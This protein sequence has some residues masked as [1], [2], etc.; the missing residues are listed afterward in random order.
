M[1][2]KWKAM[3]QKGGDLMFVSNYDHSIDDKGRFIM[4]SKFR[5]Q[6]DGRCVVTQGLD[7]NCLYI[8]QVSEWD[9]F[10]ERLR[11]LPN[12]KREIRAF[13]RMFTKNAETVEIDK[14]GRCLLSAKLRELAGIKDEIKLIGMDN[15]IELWSRE[16]WERFEENEEFDFETVAENLDII[17]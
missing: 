16:S 2:T 5:E 6:L 15:K 11:A 17:I 7:D 3:E 1:V 4:P 12:A 8:Y 13:Q 14:Q 9:A 10:M